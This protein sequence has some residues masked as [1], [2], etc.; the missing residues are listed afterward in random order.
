M[1]YRHE[2]GQIGWGMDRPHL[3]DTHPCS[4]K[5]FDKPHVFGIDL[6]QSSKF[7]YGTGMKRQNFN[8]RYGID[9]EVYQ[10]M[11]PYA[12]RTVVK[13]LDLKYRQNDLS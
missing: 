4:K 7:I 12:Q 13:S 5:Q 2:P 11:N 9:P 6:K 3:V 1:V 8:E 10:V